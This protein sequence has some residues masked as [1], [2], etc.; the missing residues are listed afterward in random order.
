MIAYNSQAAAFC[1]WRIDGDG[2]LRVTAHVLKQGVYPYSAAECDSLE[3]L[4]GIDPVMQFVPRGE[5][6]PEALASLEGKPVTVPLLAPGE[7]WHQWRDAANTLADGLTVGVVAGAP[8]VTES[9]CV[10]CD[11][12]IFDPEAIRDIIN[13]T[14]V[15]VSAGYEGRLVLR[16]GSHDGI[17]YHAIQSELRFN[18]VLLL[19]KG[20]G[21]CGSEVRIINGRKAASLARLRAASTAP[22]QSGGRGETERKG[23]INMSGNS[24]PTTLKVHIGKVQK[25]VRFSNEDDA[26]SAQLLLEEQKS[27][28]RQELDNSRA[29]NTD[30]AQRFASLEKEAEEIRAALEQAKKTIAELESPEAREALAREAAEQKEAE[31]CIIEAENHRLAHTSEWNEAKPEHGGAGS[32]DAAKPSDASARIPGKEQTQIGRKELDKQL[33]GCATMAGR[34]AVLV[35]SLLGA[36]GMKTE[37][38]TQDAFDGAFETLL[39]QARDYL[40]QLADSGRVLNGRKSPAEPGAAGFQNARDRILRPMKLRNKA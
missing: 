35:N 3:L 26:A 20:M 29:E 19:P 22:P 30:L 21:R 32:Y 14:L 13:G 38:W 16:S 25:T 23:V 33:T 37:N 31:Q 28:D 6:T 1:N 39:L 40:A 10:Q 36:R 7:E 4:P 24:T 8:R 9:G 17:T 12:R 15:E 5:F 11:M 18:H 2:M 34:R 27:A